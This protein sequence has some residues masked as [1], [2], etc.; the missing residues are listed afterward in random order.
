MFSLL[1]S[2]L[3][4]AIWYW[5]LLL[6]LFLW[7]SIIAQSCV[8]NEGFLGPSPCPL[9]SPYLP[10]LCSNGFHCVYKISANKLTSFLTLSLSLLLKFIALYFYKAWALGGSWGRGRGEQL[11]PFAL[12]SETL[13]F[14]PKECLIACVVTEAWNILGKEL[15]LQPGCA[16]FIVSLMGQACAR[17]FGLNGKLFRGKKYKTVW[18][19]FWEKAKLDC[20]REV[21][22]TSLPRAPLAPLAQSFLIPT[23]LFFPCYTQFLEK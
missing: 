14:G 13:C 23:C 4:R 10:Q 9:L 11:R 3:R 20:L 5:F 17:N 7:W 6:F 18:H 12:K 19:L 21:Q 2:F 8:Y 1:L 15:C 22:L 16:G